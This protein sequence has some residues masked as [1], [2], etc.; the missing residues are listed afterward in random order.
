ML[1]ILRDI[2]MK[3]LHKLASFS[4]NQTS[5]SDN[6]L[7]YNSYTVESRDTIENIALKYDILPSELVKLNKMSSR[8]LYPGQL[9]K[10]PNASY[11]LPP[12][13]PQSEVEVDPV[14][15][16]S[17]TISSIPNAHPLQSNPESANV[18]LFSSKSKS[19][20]LGSASR[21]TYSHD[22]RFYSQSY[23]TESEE[24][25]PIVQRFFKCRA[26]YLRYDAPEP[27]IGTL[28]LTPTAT[29]FDS[30]DLSVTLPFNQLRLARL[31]RDIDI[32]G[33]K[34]G[35]YSIHTDQT[36]MD[37]EIILNSA[38]SK[39]V[40]K[41]DSKIEDISNNTPH[42]KDKDDDFETK[43][44]AHKMSEAQRVN[45]S[46]ISG[47]EYLSQHW[48]AALKSILF[49][50]QSENSKNDNETINAHP[51]DLKN[52]S[53]SSLTLLYHHNHD[54]EKVIFLDIDTLPD[55]KNGDGGNEYWFCLLP[56]DAKKIFIFLEECSIYLAEEKSSKKYELRKTAT[57]KNSKE[58]ELLECPKKD[59]SPP[60]QDYN[61]DIP[62]L[63]DT[64]SILDDDQIIQLN[65]RLPARA[66]GY[67]WI[68]AYSNNKHGY[69]FNTMYNKLQA[70]DN[71]SPV[72]L[73]IKD[74]D[75]KVFGALASCPFK[76]SEHFYGNGETFLYTFYPSFQVFNWT[77]E[78]NY[79]IQG[80][81]D[82][83]AIGSGK[84]LYGLWLGANFY[85]GR[86]H[87]CETFA[88]PPLTLKEDF[89][90]DR[91]EVWWFGD[92]PKT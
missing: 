20:N 83:L 69:S 44:K 8:M 66:I 25:D 47:L 81:L 79:F 38:K 59:A 54:T 13:Q 72:L 61:P 53:T 37:K 35:T 60:L 46:I 65:K 43:I 55:A 31:F 10:V 27:L 64:S 11:Q 89:I 91:L 3:Q 88:N 84:G 36:R 28:L 70:C 22:S 18:K 82:S 21:P 39:P 90:V 62:S 42:D 71:D 63:L 87:S 75:A 85:H 6:Q 40:L 34:D 50:E 67:Y 49:N 12:H 48:P 33:E 16:R 2:S 76:P 52:Q 17:S 80:N 23:E 14:R 77:G 51:M 41:V 26:V 58:W 24:D 1:E 57:A 45:I 68:L 29:M 9:I 73:V 5:T 56:S 19:F 4:D 86:T 92:A 7:Q 74:K 32:Y 30:T 78:N 15:F